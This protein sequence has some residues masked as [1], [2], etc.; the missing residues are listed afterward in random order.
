MSII[1]NL[2]NHLKDTKVSVPLKQFSKTNAEKFI[3][4][5][6]FNF[7][8]LFHF[9]VE[10]SVIYIGHVKP[11]S[12]QKGGFTAVPQRPKYKISDRQGVRCAVASNNVYSPCARCAIA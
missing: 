8:I 2:N 5:K 1:M 9:S 6:M 11:P 3:I 4:S 7:V 12:H 10:L